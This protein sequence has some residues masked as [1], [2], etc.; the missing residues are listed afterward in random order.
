M[1]QDIMWKLFE[2][3]GRIDVYID[4]KETL[5]YNEDINQI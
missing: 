1:L 2:K 4:Y 5:K 3:T